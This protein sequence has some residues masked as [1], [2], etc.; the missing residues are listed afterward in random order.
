MSM[1]ARPHPNVYS[2]RHSFLVYSHVKCEFSKYQ[3][4]YAIYLLKLKIHI[5]RSLR[6][7]GGSILQ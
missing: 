2:F 5:K 1:T 7:K 3:E 4:I 6:Y